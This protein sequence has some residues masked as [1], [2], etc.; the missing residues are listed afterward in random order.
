MTIRPDVLMRHAI[1]AAKQGILA[2]Q[3][4]FGCAIARGE[5]VVA[6]CHNKVW[7]N[8]DITAH[9]EVTAL[10]EACRNTNQILL[11]DCVV[12][13]TCEPCPMCMSALHWA[14]VQKVYYGAAIA[15]AAAAGFNEL[16]IDAAT[17]LQR[18]GSHVQ[19]QDGVLVEECKAL[20]S[21]W[22]ARQGTAY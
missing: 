8:T 12:A 3:S 15:D 21:L 22:Q 19:L 2:K 11:R 10:R 5:E 6:A 14:R 17:L 13:A 1:D 7:Q 9:A 20:F 4:P 18:G 16:T